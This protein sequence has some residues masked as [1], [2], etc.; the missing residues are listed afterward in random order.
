MAPNFGEPR[1]ESLF[2]VTP[3]SPRLQVTFT[4]ARVVRGQTTLIVDQSQRAS[5][6]R[7]T[8]L[9]L[10]MLPQALSQIACAADVELS[11][12]LAQQ[13]VGIFHRSPTIWLKKLERH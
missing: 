4:P 8:Y 7:G 3:S 13:D 1:G 11:I 2:E 5:I 9:P 10:V 12:L 6:V